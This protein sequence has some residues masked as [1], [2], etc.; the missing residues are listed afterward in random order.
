MYRTV[1]GVF[2]LKPSTIVQINV[3]NNLDKYLSL[4]ASP[5]YL[6]PLVRLDMLHAIAVECVQFF[7]NLP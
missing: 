5:G 7:N 1:R 2:V 3:H 6:L 4:P